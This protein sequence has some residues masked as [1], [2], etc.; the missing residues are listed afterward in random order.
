M[1]AAA[2][3]A[4]IVSPPELS[5]NEGRLWCE[6]IERRCGVFFPETQWRHL[7]RRLW[8][9]MLAASIP[10]YSQYY[11]LL[12]ENRWQTEW[13]RLLGEVPFPQRFSTSTH[14][15]INTSAHRMHPS[16]PILR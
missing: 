8:E 12:T 11:H 15:R 13:S 2:A 4:A 3:V 9:R 6:L 14:E 1:P 10:A 7:R 16:L 5:L